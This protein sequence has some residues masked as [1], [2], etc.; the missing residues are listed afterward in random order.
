[1]G[2]FNTKDKTALHTAE[3]VETVF[4]KAQGQADEHSSVVFVIGTFSALSEN[5]NWKCEMVVCLHYEN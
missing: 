1:M 4:N 3:G 5:E 2:G